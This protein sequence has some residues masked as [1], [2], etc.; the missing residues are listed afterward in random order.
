M[1][2]DITVY[3]ENAAGE[4]VAVPVPTDMGLSLMEALKANEF[5]ILATCGGMALC[6]TCHVELLEAPELPEASDDE[7]YM[8]E[9]LPNQKEGSRLS[10]QIK[11]TP[12]LDGMVLRLMSDH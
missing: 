10:C 8:L 4:R 9:N 3:V 2:E 6:A 12:E 1:Q 7:L 5:D 11:V